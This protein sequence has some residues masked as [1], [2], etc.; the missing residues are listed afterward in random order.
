M[1]EVRYHEV[2]EKEGFTRCPDFLKADWPPQKIIG[3]VWCRQSLGV[4]QVCIKKTEREKTGQEAANN[5][6]RG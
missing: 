1:P 5:C 6:Y 3:V 4:L 2:T